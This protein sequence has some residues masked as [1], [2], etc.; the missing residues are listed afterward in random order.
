MVPRAS[1]PSVHGRGRRQAVTR[2]NGPGAPVHRSSASRAARPGTLG[3]MDAPT[4]SPITDEEPPDTIPPQTLEALDAAT[5]AIASAVS[6]E[7][8]LQVITDRI[9]PLVGARYAAL[10][11]VR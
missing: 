11:I 5:V 1:L 2:P 9:R 6:L 3:G 7:D 4:S 8:V 10:G